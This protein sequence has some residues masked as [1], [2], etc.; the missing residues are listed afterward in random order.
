MPIPE[1]FAANR[2]WAERMRAKD[3]E[4]FA[5]LVAGQSPELLWI[6]CSDSRLLPTDMI[7]RRPGEV[8][9]HRNVANLVV[10]GDVNCSAVIEYAVEV[11]QVRHVVVC[12]HYGCGG[13]RAAM[14]GHRLGDTGAWLRP[15]RV[16]DAQERAALAGLSD[17][18]RE[19]RLCERN[20]EAQ[21]ENLCRNE[22]IRTAWARGQEVSVHGWIYSLS[23]GLL[24]A[25]TSTDGVGV[26]LPEA[27]LAPRGEREWAPAQPASRTPAR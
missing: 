9:V 7:G 5:R 20:V 2:A 27:V 15:I 26:A 12:G 1:L 22:A 25:L 8:F 4:Y 17:R 24:R 3:P 11:L 18:E 13:V 10:D 19:D 21:V 23:D 16:L 14:A 6:G